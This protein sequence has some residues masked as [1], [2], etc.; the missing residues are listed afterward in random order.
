[1]NKFGAKQTI[2]LGTKHLYSD[3]DKYLEYK[4]KQMFLTLGEKLSEKIPVTKTEN[5][6]NLELRID[7]YVFTFAQLME[8][9]KKV[10]NEYN[11]LEGRR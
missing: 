2:S 5:D 7:C 11:M 3:W 9:R 6:G 10:I 1:M 4:K 8:Y